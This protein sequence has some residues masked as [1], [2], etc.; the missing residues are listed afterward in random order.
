MTILLQGNQERYDEL[1]VVTTK[2]VMG[3]FMTVGAMRLQGQQAGVLYMK[4]SI[5]SLK[6]YFIN[7]E[8]DFQYLNLFEQKFI[9]SGVQAIVYAK[10]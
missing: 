7:R 10:R 8:S 9:Q 5:A 3:H 1:G 4:G 2:A 6:H